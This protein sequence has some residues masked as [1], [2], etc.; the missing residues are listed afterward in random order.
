M[1]Y[2]ILWYEDNLGENS[3][4]GEQISIGVILLRECSAGSFDYWSVGIPNRHPW[5][6][7]GPQSCAFR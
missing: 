7:L 3:D 1:T 6:C 5:S 2:D 4:T